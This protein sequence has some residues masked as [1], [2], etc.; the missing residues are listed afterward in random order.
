[1][2]RQEAHILC[3]YVRACCPQ[4]TFDDLTPLV[5]YDL[6]RDLSL[7]DCRTAVVAVSKRKPFVAPAEIIAEVKSIREERIRRKPI[8]APSPEPGQYLKSLRASI[9]SLADGFDIRRALPA[10]GCEPNEEYRQTRTEVDPDHRVRKAVT[11]APCPWHACNAAAGNPCVDPVTAKPLLNTPAHHS[12]LVAANL[13]QPDRP[14]DPE[15]NVVPLRPWV[16]LP[17]DDEY[18]KGHLT[19]LAEADA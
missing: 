17:G 18:V 8:P 16:E 3:R 14:V 2:N 7:D 5:W 13:V 4:Q 6:L 19:R 12:R 1:M 11:D 10:G 9:K 15:A